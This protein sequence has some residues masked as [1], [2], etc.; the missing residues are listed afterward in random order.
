MTSKILFGT[1]GIPISTKQ[2]DSVNGIKRVRELGLDAME[3]EFVRGVHMNEA[4]AR[5]VGRAGAENNVLLRVHAPY[6][7]NLNSKEKAKVAAS[8][9]RILDSAKIG[10]IAGA[11]IVTFHPA[12]FQGE[13]KKKVLEKVIGEIGEIQDYLKEHKIRIALAPETTGKPTQ[14]GSL[15]ETIQMAEA[16]KG[17]LPMVDFAH[18]HARENGRFKGKKD[19]EE[20]IGSIPKRFLG[21]LFMHASG[22]NF[23][24]KGERN[25][26]EMED[27]TNTF[28]Y[29]H[30]LEALKDLKVSG[31]IICESPNIEEDALLMQKYYRRL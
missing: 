18:L 14:L 6:F 8:K 7:I 24:E 15:E 9:K 17:V 13:E 26:L 2:H 25:H 12:Y 11:R 22:I 5:E 31:S 29:K 23:S 4:T 30:M 1:A 19:F 20:A 3:L 21:E 10:A 27:K 28:N 16:V